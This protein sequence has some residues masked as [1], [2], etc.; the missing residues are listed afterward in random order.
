[1]CDSAKTRRYV[2]RD[3]RRKRIFKHERPPVRK[4][5]EA[6]YEE[7][8]KW[9][10]KSLLDAGC[11]TGPDAQ[12]IMELGTRYVGLDAIEGN[13]EIARR[14]NPDAEFRQGFL[15]ELPFPDDSFDWVYMS[16]VWGILPS[17]KDMATAIRECIRVAR[18]RVYN[19]DFYW[20][21]NFKERYMAIPQNLKLEIRRISYDPPKK[22][23]NCMWII[24]LEELK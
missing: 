24:Y 21:S 8:A 14:E 16:G 23:A 20:L 6:F 10:P 17:T 2:I 11:G 3:Y 22:K 12:P 9:R 1:M 4:A 13:L 18:S 19:L 15:Q 5:R 7:V